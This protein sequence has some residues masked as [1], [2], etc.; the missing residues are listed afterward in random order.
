MSTLK[1]A[2][3]AELKIQLK[4]S[5]Q[6]LESFLNLD[7]AAAET[8]ELDQSKVGRLSRIDA[9]QQQAMAQASSGAHSRQLMRVHQALLKIE[10]GDYGYCEECGKDIP[11][12]RLQV[13]PES[14]FCVTCLQAQEN[15]S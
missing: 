4:E 3:L 9:L 5:E 15:E 13:Q 7:V 8:V 10:Q 6:Q 11:F 2:Q 14:D 1:A 12:A